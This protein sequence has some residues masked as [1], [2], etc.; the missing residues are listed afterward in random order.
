MSGEL[1]FNEVAAQ[2]FMSI[3]KGV[4]THVQIENALIKIGGGAKDGVEYKKEV[5]KAAGWE[6]GAL[7][8]YGAYSE[9]AASTFNNIRSVLVETADKEEVL[10][11]LAAVN[12]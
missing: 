10:Q 7:T 4:P 12:S 1:E 11:R 5:L 3:P 9:K 8:S 6:Y 2:D